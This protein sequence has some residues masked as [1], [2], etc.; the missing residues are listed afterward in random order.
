ME[1]KV[2]YYY[3]PDNGKKKCHLVREGSLKEGKK[4]MNSHEKLRISLS[5][6]EGRDVSHFAFCIKTI[7]HNWLI[8]TQTWPILGDIQLILKY[9]I[10]GSANSSWGSSLFLSCEILLYICKWNLGGENYNASSCKDM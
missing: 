1:N 6:P 3:Y 8:L 4:A 5:L 2:T 9:I 7:G 10:Y